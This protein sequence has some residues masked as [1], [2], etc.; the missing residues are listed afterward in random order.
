MSDGEI[1]QSL[2]SRRD[3]HQNRLEGLRADVTALAQE[4][5]AGD[6]G[7]LLRAA[8][9]DGAI[10]QERAAVDWL[11]D[12]IEAIEAGGLPAGSSADAGDPLHGETGTA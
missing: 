10:A 5:A 1:V 4:H 6:R 12:T 8:A 9:Y 3:S 11:D 7:L 2:R